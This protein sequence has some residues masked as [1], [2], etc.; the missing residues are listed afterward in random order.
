MHIKSDGP[1]EGQVMPVR[2]PLIRRGRT[3]TTL[4]CPEGALSG[5]GA[6]RTDGP[7]DAQPSRT[8]ES[9]IRR[10]RPTDSPTGKRRSQ[11][12]CYFSIPPPSCSVCLSWFGCVA[13]TR[14]YGFWHMCWLWRRV[15]LSFLASADK[16]APHIG[17]TAL[18]ASANFLCRTPLLRSKQHVYLR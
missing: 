1:D 12:D 9:E 16:S 17:K 5:C 18:A 8:R 13:I 2:G 3:I 6:G 11:V 10:L 14:T 7:P 4:L 15:R